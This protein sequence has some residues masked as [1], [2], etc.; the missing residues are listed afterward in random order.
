M[1]TH[2]PTLLYSER[3]SNG[4]AV[5]ATDGSAYHYPKLATIPHTIVEPV[6]AAFKDS[7]LC[8]YKATVAAAIATTFS[9]TYSPAFSSAYYPTQS[10]AFSATDDSTDFTTVS[11][12][13]I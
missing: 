4:A 13:I 9:S 7:G 6:H 10:A 1:S 12:T 8:T 5:E 11:A 3:S 2:Y